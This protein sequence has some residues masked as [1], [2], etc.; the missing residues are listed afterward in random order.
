ME[1]FAW[2]SL[3]FVWRS[4]TVLAL[5]GAGV[6]NQDLEGIKKKIESEKKGLSQLQIKEGSVRESLSKVETEL[7]EKNRQLKTANTRWAAL[8]E[9][10]ESKK[11]EGEQLDHSV[12]ARR[13]LLQ[14]RAAALYRWQR[15][16]SPLVILNGAASL[17]QFLRRQHYLQEAISFDRDLVT[18]LQDESARLAVVQEQLA[19]KKSELDGQKQAIALAQD[20]VRQDAEKKKI[21]LANLSREKETRQRALK[22]MEAAA[23]RLQKM[24]DEIARRAALKPRDRPAPPSSGIGFDALRG[25]LDWPV[26]GEIVAPFGKFK[27][28]EFAAEV[29][30]KGI[31]IDAPLGEGIKAIERGKVVYANRFSGYGR[32]VIIDHGE[33][34]YTIYGHLSEILKKTGDEIRRGEILGRVGDSDSAAG[35]RLYFELRKDGHSLDPIPWFKKQ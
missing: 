9:E 4:L 10:M 33:R 12:S 19:K 11:L 13:E 17:S 22:Q 5:L 35:S 1:A 18:K 30:R 34:Y 7:A 2:R 26:K 15:G 24:M 16:G 20:A 14:Q 27:H 8:Q 31:D 6:G 3:I 23:Q 21:L 25:R 32:M 29:V 28:P